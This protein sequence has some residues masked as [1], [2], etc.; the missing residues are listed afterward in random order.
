[1]KP[2]VSYVIAG[3]FLTAYLATITVA[4]IFGSAFIWVNFLFLFAGLLLILQIIVSMVRRSHYNLSHAAPG[5]AVFAA[6]LAT[7]LLFG[8]LKKLNI[9]TALNEEPPFF[10][11]IE[12]TL[13]PY[14][15]LLWLTLLF[16]IAL[17]VRTRHPFI[18]ATAILLLLLSVSDFLLEPQSDYSLNRLRHHLSM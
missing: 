5:L 16:Y 8:T 13:Q 7:T 14:F 11:L 3:S 18:I 2:I 1:M 9:S 4:L 6:G 10:A 17:S 15:I 12:F